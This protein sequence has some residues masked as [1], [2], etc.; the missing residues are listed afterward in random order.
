MGMEVREGIRRDR[1]QTW[2]TPQIRQIN[3]TMPRMPTRLLRRH[4]AL[5]SLRWLCSRPGSVT[6]RT[7][8]GDPSGDGA[9]PGG[10][11]R[12]D[13][14]L[15]TM[16]TTLTH[17]AIV[18]LFLVSF[19][20]LATAQFISADTYTRYELLPPDTHQFKIYYEVTETRAGTP[21]HFNQIRE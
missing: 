10:D 6:R 11:S 3:E 9:E 5:L 1:P 15:R 16:K 4:T 21:F 18:L 17:S 8:D 14:Q 13:S 12:T 2:Y 7:A 20:G 19:C